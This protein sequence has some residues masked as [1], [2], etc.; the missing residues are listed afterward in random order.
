LKT[1]VG[2]VIPS[3]ISLII[4]L[5]IIEKIIIFAYSEKLKNLTR[6]RLFG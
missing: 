6:Y 5:L 2:T 4:F 3:F 1:I